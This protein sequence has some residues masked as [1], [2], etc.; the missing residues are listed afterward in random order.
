M[1]P[2]LHP[3]DPVSNALRAL[4][5]EF[6]TM[7]VPPASNVAP[8]PD[9]KPLQRSLQTLPMMDIWVADAE[10]CVGLWKL[11]TRP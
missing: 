1:H 7:P 9:R 11:T 2:S 6:F 3:G 4:S 5:A 10:M 8:A